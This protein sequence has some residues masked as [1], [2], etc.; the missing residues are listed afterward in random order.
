MRVLSVGMV[1]GAAVFGVIGLGQ[2]ANAAPT[3]T[4]VT[5][6]AAAPADQLSCV[7]NMLGQ[8]QRAAIASLFAA[9]TD[10][11]Q[12]AREAPQGSAQASEDMTR[13]LTECSGRNRW[14][15]AQKN[16]AMQYLISLGKVSQIAV[17]QG[18]EWA[19]AMERYAPFGARMLPAEG[20][21]SDHALAMI[22]AG[23]R[24][25]G[26]K[27]DEGEQLTPVLDYLMATRALSSAR[28]AFA[29]LR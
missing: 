16:A 1:L 18:P 20:K 26:L 14:S 17:R 9:Q 3:V 24:A 29:A 13:V 12:E 28:T 2:V 19:V 22:A 15:D 5:S 4:Q 6:V 21:P 27:V 11:P 25:N 10:D 7:D 8:Q 23:G